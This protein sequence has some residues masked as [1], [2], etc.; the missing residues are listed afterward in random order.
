MHA[1][2]SENLSDV[3]CEVSYCSDFP[4]HTLCLDDDSTPDQCQRSLIDD[5]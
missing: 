5:V 4:S 1:C 3:E 2:L